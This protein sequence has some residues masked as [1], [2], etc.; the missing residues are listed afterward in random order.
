MYV[1]DMTRCVNE[2]VCMCVRVQRRGGS[3][4]QIKLFY[5]PLSSSRNSAFNSSSVGSGSFIAVVP[6][7]VLLLFADESPCFMLARTL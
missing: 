4:V 7:V 3:E 2:T 1:S 6:V 5:L